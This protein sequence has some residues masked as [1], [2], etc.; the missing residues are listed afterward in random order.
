MLLTSKL[1]EVYLFYFYVHLYT[2]KDE[3]LVNGESF[4][5]SVDEAIGKGT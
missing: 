3:V 5:C 2:D 4:A 1:L